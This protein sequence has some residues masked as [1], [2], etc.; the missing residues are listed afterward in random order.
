[1]IRGGRQL[2]ALGW[3][4]VIRNEVSQECIMKHCSVMPGGRQLPL[5]Q[6]SCSPAVCHILQ[7][8]RMFVIQMI[9]EPREDYVGVWYNL[10]S[11]LSAGC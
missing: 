9:F 10:D 4:G 1:M 5:M 3:L 8:Q 2:N 7:L 11:N 6:K